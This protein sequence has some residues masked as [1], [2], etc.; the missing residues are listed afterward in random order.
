VGTASW[1]YTGSATIPLSGTASHL[2]LGIFEV[3]TAPLYLGFLPAGYPPFLTTATLSY[4]VNGTSF[5]GPSGSG[6]PLI[7]ETGGV[8]VPEPSTAMAVLW[9]AGSLPLTWILR[10]RRLRGPHAA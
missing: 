1:L 7:L 5:N 9:A 6:I 3:T 8:S 10:R 2:L 4:T